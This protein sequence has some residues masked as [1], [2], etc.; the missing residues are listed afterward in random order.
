VKRYKPLKVSERLAALKALDGWSYDTEAD[1]IIK[2]FQ[3][4]DFGAAFAFMTRV[5]CQA[6]KLDHH[7]EWFNVYNRVKV[8]LTTHDMGGVTEKDLELA[9]FMNK[10]APSVS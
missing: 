9:R 5:A 2:T 1:A 6:E 7:P 3:F 10:V 4:T 8:R